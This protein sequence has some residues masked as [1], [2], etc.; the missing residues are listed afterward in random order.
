MKGQ[1]FADLSSSTE[2]RFWIN[3]PSREEAEKA[4]QAG[5]ISCTTNPAYCSKLLE[6]D[7]ELVT[8]AVDHGI[9]LHTDPELVAEYA[10]RECAREL[11]KLFLPHYESS[12]GT[13]GFVTI[14]DDPRT[15]ESSDAII[16][17]VDE[18]RKLA[19]N[20]MAK[21]PVI[22]TGL[23]AIEYCVETNTPLCATEIFGISQAVSA[24][25]R[26]E[27]A[28]AR[29]GNRPPF[30]VT[31]ISGIFD[32]YLLRMCEIHSIDINGDTV[33]KSG[34]TL[35]RKQYRLMRERNYPGVLLGGG[36]RRTEHF[37]GLVGGATHIT[38]NWSTAEELLGNA[39]P[40]TSRIDDTTPDSDIAGL[41]AAFPDF[42][43]AYHED[44]MTISEYASYGPVQLFRNAFLKGWYQF[45]VEIAKRKTAVLR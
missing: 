35:A 18:G 32:E 25:S 2:T 45:L 43:R 36:A 20:Y 42:A 33:E 22:E 8:G 19:P 23:R 11:M 44:G 13:A 1:Y 6:S 34:L 41:M 26:Y 37:T 27:S 3:N 9:L 15:D 31:H 7:P 21:I 5:A 17:G 10:Y 4:I 14:Q 30:F 28:A 29:T 38:I 12:G 39:G 16:A 40:V 24:C